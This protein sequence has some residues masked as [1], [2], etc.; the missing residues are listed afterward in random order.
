MSVKDLVLWVRLR[1]MTT[2][3][4]QARLPR[5]HDRVTVDVGCLVIDELVAQGLLVELLLFVEQVSVVVDIVQAVSS[6]AGLVLLVMLALL[7]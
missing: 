2:H 4:V 3:L 7:S 1:S 5:L 6:L